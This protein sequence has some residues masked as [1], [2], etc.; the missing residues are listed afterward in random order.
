[1]G[2]WHDLA[3][4][5]NNDE[6]EDLLYTYSI[7]FISTYLIYMYVSSYIVSLNPPPTTLYSKNSYYPILDRR[8]QINLPK[9]TWAKFWA[10]PLKQ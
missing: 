5:N 6:T 7:H 9:I 4:D 2:R 10:P 8:K 1:M 3:E